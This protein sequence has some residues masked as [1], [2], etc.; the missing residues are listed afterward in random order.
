MKSCTKVLIGLN[1]ILEYMQISKPLFYQFLEMGLPARPINN[2]WYAHKDNIDE[3][4]KSV[5]R[6]RVKDIPRDAE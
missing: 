2:R 4:F 3:F 5:T 1:E 6:H